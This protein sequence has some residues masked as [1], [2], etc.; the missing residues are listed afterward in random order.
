LQA[1]EHRS[2]EAPA[3]NG[4]GVEVDAILLRVRLQ[5][6]RVAVEDVFL[7]WRIVLQ[8]RMPDLKSVVVVLILEAD[9]RS[10]VAQFV[11]AGLWQLGEPR[12]VVAQ[13]FDVRITL[14]RRVAA[15]IRAPPRFA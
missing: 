14:D 2:R 3:I 13:E 1:V 10:V 5:D 9:A 12:G 11:F 4:G 7:M 15:V 8:E 6:G